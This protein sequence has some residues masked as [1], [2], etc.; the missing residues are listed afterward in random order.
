[1]ADLQISKQVGA[2]L[3]ECQSFLD[4]VTKEQP[5]RLTSLELM[6]LG[7]YVRQVR[8]AIRQQRVLRHS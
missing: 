7:T 5:R 1:M 8:I 3:Q 6:L 2:F 4:E